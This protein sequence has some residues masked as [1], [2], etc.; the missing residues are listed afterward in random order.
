VVSLP[1][2]FNYYGTA[3]NSIV[4]AENGAITFGSNITDIS[5]TNGDLTSLSQA[6]A[7]TIY[8][9]WTNL[10][11][12]PSTGGNV[13]YKQE[14]DRFIIQWDRTDLDTIASNNNGG[15]FQVILHQTTGRID[16][17]YKDVDFNPT[18]VNL[19]PP[20]EFKNGNRNTTIGLTGATSSL[21][22]LFSNGSGVQDGKS[23][24]GV[25]SISFYVN[26][27][28]ALSNVTS[29]FIY[30]EP[31]NTPANGT[32]PS[33][34]DGNVTLSSASST[35]LNGGNLTVTYVFG[36]SNTDQLSILAGN[37]I[38]LNGNTILYN[39]NIIGTISTNQNGFNGTSLVVNFTTNN[40]T[41]AAVE[42]LI[43]RLA[44]RTTS[45][46]PANLRTINIA[47]NDGNGGISEGIGNA[48]V[49]IF[50]APGNDAPINTIPNTQ[51]IN[52]DTFIIFSSANGNQISISDPDIPTPTNEILEIELTATNGIINLG[53]KNNI[54]VF[55]NDGDGYVRISGTINNLNTALNGL[56]FTPNANY[57]N[58]LISNLGPATITIKTN[59]L[60]NIGGAEGSLFDQDTITINVN[61]VNDA[62]INT[63][64]SSGT[65]I[66][67]EDTTL[68]IN[69]IR[70]TDVDANETDNDPATNNELDVTLTVVNGTI[71]LANTTGINFVT[72][73]NTGRKTITIRG[74]LA[75]LNSVLGTTGGNGVIYQGDLNFNGTDTFTITTNDRG[76][77]GITDLSLYPNSGNSDT[78]SF[79][80]TVTAV[81]D[82]PINTVP[83]AQT[84]DEDTELI[85]SSVNGNALSIA[86]V[87][88][89]ERLAPNNTMKVNLSVGNGTLRF[90]NATGL[91]FAT[92]DNTGTKSTIIFTGTLS[93]INTAFANGL[94][95]KGNL[96]YNQIN[97]DGDD[98]LQITTE[99][100]GNTGTG[101]NLTASSS[102]NITVNAVN[103]APVN[104]VPSAQVITEDTDLVFSGANNNALQV[105]DVDV[106]ETDSPE[107]LIR[108]TLSV[109][110][111]T[112]KFADPGALEFAV[113]NN[114]G[115]PGI[116]VIGTLAQ[117]NEALN[118]GLIYRGG[119]D[120]NGPDILTMITSDLGNTGSGGEKQDTKTVA[121]TVNAVND[122]PVV[123]LSS[124]QQSVSE[125][126]TLVFNDT[127]GNRITV[128]DVDINTTANQNQQSF[129][130]RQRVTL[131]VLNGIINLG[132]TANID[133]VEGAN[134][135]KT[136]TFEGTIAQ[137]NNAL[138]G[139]SYQGDLNYNGDDTLTITTDDLGNNGVILGVEGATSLTNTKTIA[140]TVN[141]V[142]DAPLVTIATNAL[143]QSVNEDT[144]FTLT[145]ITVS[146]IDIDTS[147]NKQSFVDQQEI[148]LT[149]T[150][151][152]LNFGTNATTLKNNSQLLNVSGEGTNTLTFRGTIANVNAALQDIKY[153]G[154]AN[155]NGN[156]TLIVTTNDLGNTGSGGAKSDTKNLT[157]V[158]NKVNDAP[159][160]N[161]A[162]GANVQT[163]AEDQALAIAGV[164][165]DDIDINSDL[166]KQTFTDLQSVTLTVNKGTLQLGTTT[167][168]T[169]IQY[170]GFNGNVNT[171]TF[172]GKVADVNTALATLT[173][174]GYQ[175]FNGEDTLTIT[176]NDLGNSGI[177][178]FNNPLS[179]T[180]TVKINVTPEHDSPINILPLHQDA[181]TASDFILSQENKNALFIKSVDVDHSGGANHRVTLSVLSGVLKFVDHSGITFE[182]GSDNTGQATITFEGT[183]P[184]INQAL[185]T[186]LIYTSNQGF[187]GQENLNI[188]TYKLD[189]S[190]EIITGI[191]D[192][193]SMN[194]LVRDPNFRNEVRIIPAFDT[195][196]SQNIGFT[197]VNGGWAT[198]NDFPRMLADVNGD[199]FAD[200]VAF[201]N[202]AVVSLKQ[203][204][205]HF[206]NS[207]S[208]KYWFYQK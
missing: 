201:G 203:W 56:K 91:T 160:V 147:V 191:Q 154:N 196:T 61:A 133:I 73:D 180:K 199:G 60:G 47:V 19:S 117:I 106:N 46:A 118:T 168:L 206:S 115:N 105:A 149:V 2:S 31:F 96:N 204:R 20:D 33:I 104:T 101:G 95:Y 143:T 39:N 80:I 114:N 122:A 194:I 36:V 99:D 155:Y 38:T 171:I 6:V 53:T 108:L 81:N 116:S 182:D 183:I 64:P 132:T 55:D 152:T 16:F 127:N 68:L 129:G 22:Y 112:V 177:N 162:D 113:G 28:P 87:D 83:N 186:G 93:A 130:D 7:N 29:S 174:Q 153:Q 159:V 179:N 94:V 92:G 189:N 18:G 170:S 98:V 77:T 166:N 43:E 17:V 44:Y 128:S 63:I 65:Q 176:T 10:S 41:L 78:D 158:V 9:F 187:L 49:D 139:L 71:K 21:Q 173:Y 40:A 126:T 184:Q 110:N 86:D 137:V 151:G 135:T 26:D 205:W 13:I 195:P 192:I 90:I 50:V 188:A 161:L 145:G 148:T 119:Q 163:V 75:N 150:K 207:Q 24:T 124:D 14:G 12:S 208:S 57:N 97:G 167:G 146:D 1:W 141:S 142:N 197:K 190:G 30:Q 84:V 88:V 51:T 175:D 164:T 45:N 58:N 54:T 5:G 102:V 89:N 181:D 123:N 11:N 140:L 62:P 59:D 76:N 48:N 3:Y 109:N 42:A 107:N 157:I 156:D 35:N 121:L 23:L 27:A 165:I 8:P 131:T 69:S 100:Q 185:A 198:Q 52:E 172:K 200:I 67:A 66:V 25:T 138:N 169:E 4:I 37:L 202:S 70:I 72:G 193:D 178:G 134:G 85:F 32:T 82:A 125:D 144:Q 34:I 136:I 120:Y 79:N 103:D 74:T 15:T 111:G